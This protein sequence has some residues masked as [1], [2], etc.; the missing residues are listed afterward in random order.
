M[1][2]KISR[3]EVA[4][5]E[6]C[7]EQTAELPIDADFTVADYL[8]EVKKVLKSKITP[9]IASKQISGNAL[10]VEGTAIVSI[11]YLDSDN[12]LCTAE[13]EVPFKKSFEAASQLNNASCEVYSEAVTH[14]CRAITERRFSVKGSLKLDVTVYMIEKNEII[15]DID[16]DCFEQLKG[17]TSATTP[18]GI[19]DKMMVIDEEITLPQT[20]PAV[21]RI[22]RSDAFA[23][24]TDSKIISNKIIIKGNLNIEIAYC[25]YENEF[26]KHSVDIPFNQI[27]DMP[28][29][30]ELCECDAKVNVCGLS[31]STRTSQNGECRSF[32]TVCKLNLTA[33]ARCNSNI[34]VVFDLYST[35]YPTTTKKNDTKFTH[36]IKQTNESFLCKKRISLPENCG[37]KVIDLWCFLNQTSCRPEQNGMIIM[38]S[39]S[40]C[41]LTKNDDDTI[42][43]ERIIDFEYPIKLDG[44]HFSPH[45][46]PEVKILSSNFSP[47]SSNEIEL[48]IELMISATVYDSTTISLITDIEI[49]ENN[50]IAADAALIAYFADTGENVW[51]ISKS[52]L[53]NRVELLELNKLTDEVIKT[54]K[55]L[56]IP[57]MI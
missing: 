5:E 40:V 23:V 54:P 31:V 9:Y 18:L 17:E 35:R 15:S 27:I 44:K 39:L 16:S 22:I 26:L 25:S 51:D 24:I 53:A 55:M 19:T 38:G 49:D 14:S 34:P 47:I 32:M 12:F 41:I 45:C 42:F 1:D 4:T 3:F 28:G 13:H 21:H 30:S 50:P 46:R 56:L 52:F 33:F 2:N 10:I 48:K 29:I 20:M 7:L 37:N 57:R 43:F 36:I 8:G 6:I 11:I